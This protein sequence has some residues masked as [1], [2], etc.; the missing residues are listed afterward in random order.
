M[1]T[2]IQ[3]RGFEIWQSVID[4]YKEPT[5]P[6]TNEREINLIKIIPKPQMHF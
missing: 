1:K 6:L 5:V 2:F 4:G 3:T